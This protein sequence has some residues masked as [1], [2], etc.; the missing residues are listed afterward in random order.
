M[1]EDYDVEAEKAKLVER[2]EELQKEST[3]DCKLLSRSITAKEETA[4]M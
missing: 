4:I 3:R 2:M 1:P